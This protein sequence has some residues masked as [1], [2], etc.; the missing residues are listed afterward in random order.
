MGQDTQSGNFRTSDGCAISYSLNGSQKPGAPRFALVHSLALDRSIWSGVVRELADRAAILT[1]DCRGHG[2]SERRA[3]PFTAEL[4]AQDLAEL[5]DHVGWP[6][7]TVAGCSM[8]GCV[9]QAFAGLYGPRVSALGLIDTTAWYGEDAPKKWRERADVART[10]GL[11]GMVEF[12]NTRWFGDAFR[13]AHP[14][15]LKAMSDVFLANDVDCYAATCAMLGDADLRIYLPVMKMPVAVIVGEED[16]ATPVAMA[17]YLHDAIAGSTLTI[18][19]GAR[20]LA[21][22]ESPKQIASQLL[23][24]LHR[25]DF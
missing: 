2:R 5:L 20:H 24:L 12:Q 17:Q 11:A 4:F 14:E 6:A 25:S 7:A 3:G 13:A 8:G 19:K 1:Y 21:P 18:L 10:K 15:I 23:E 22:V 16:Y 9:A